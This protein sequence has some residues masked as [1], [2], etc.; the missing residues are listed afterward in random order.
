MAASATEVSGVYSSND[1]SGIPVGL[2]RVQGAHT[3]ALCCVCIA[4]H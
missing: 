2:C 1:N 3:P 4:T